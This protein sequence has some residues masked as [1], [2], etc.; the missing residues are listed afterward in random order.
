MI[1]SALLEQLKNASVSDRIHLIEVLLNSLKPDIR[2]SSHQ[3]T[4][5]QRPLRGKLIHYDNPY[6]PV[7]AEDWEAS[8]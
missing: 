6:E 5:E 2:S 4:T 8:A 7:A 3:S 1:D